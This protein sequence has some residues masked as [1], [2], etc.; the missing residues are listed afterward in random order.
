MET[1]MATAPD[2]IRSRPRRSPRSTHRSTKRA[3]RR[4]PHRNR[5]APTRRP[6]CFQIG[7]SRSLRAPSRT[8]PKEG[9]HLG[10]RLSYTGAFAASHPTAEAGGRGTNRVIHR[11]HRHM[12]RKMAGPKEHE[13]PANEPKTA[14]AASP[15][16]HFL[17][18]D[19]QSDTARFLAELKE[20]IRQREAIRGRLV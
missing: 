15:P 3:K 11:F 18:S 10:K 12:G 4:E 9:I 2:A 7:N 19:L 5:R 1:R 20:S 14:P 8:S 16:G 6:S 17:N 13:V